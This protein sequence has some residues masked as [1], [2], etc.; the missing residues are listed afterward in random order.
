MEKGKVIEVIDSKWNITI[1]R[2]TTEEEMQKL[3]VQIE[4]TFDP[5][6]NSTIQLENCRKLSNYLVRNEITIGDLESEELLEKSVPLNNMLNRLKIAGILPKA[7][8][9]I[10][11][12][13]LLE[14][15][16]QKKGFTLE[17][18]FDIEFYGKRS[19]NDLDLFKLYL[20]EIGQYKILSRE[21]ELEL[22]TKAQAGDNEARNKLV[23]HNLRLVI[24]VAK[25]Y[26]SQEISL[27]DL[28]LAGNE[29]LMTA[30]RK[31]DPSL[32]YKFSTYATWWIRQSLQKAVMECGR[33]IRIPAH[34]HEYIIKFRKEMAIYYTENG[35]YPS[36]EYLGEKFELSPERVLNIKLAMEPIISLSTPIGSEDKD[37]T[38]GEMLE[39]EKNPFDDSIETMDTEEL[40]HELINSEKLTEKERD[41]LKHRLGFYVNTK[42]LEEIGQQYGLSRERIRQIERVALKKLLKAYHSKKFYQYRKRLSR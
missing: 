15:Y 26:L 35:E 25:R 36:N 39:D 22:A 1:D 20:S 18:D 42:T 17:N 24:P 38:L 27:V 19:D 3:L 4:R 13:N 5:T 23:E 33:T 29:G 30:A 10:K 32:G 7:Y 37:T 34:I 2:T 14:V 12:T 11:L 41:I 21:E 9:F 16:S 31:F 40:A 6:D 8:S 28:V